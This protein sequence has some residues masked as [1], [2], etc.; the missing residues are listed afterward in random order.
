MTII[1]MNDGSKAPLPEGYTVE[2]AVA[3]LREVGH[4]PVS[5]VYPDGTTVELVGEAA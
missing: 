2:R 3:I 5:V 4:T 1:Y